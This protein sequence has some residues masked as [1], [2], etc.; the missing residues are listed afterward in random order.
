[1]KRLFLT[2]LCLLIFCGI[3]DARML[4]GVAGAVVSSSS[5]GNIDSFETSPSGGQNIAAYS[6]YEYIAF[7]FTGNG[8]DVHKISLNLRD[9]GSP[10]GLQVAICTDNSGSPSTTCQAMDANI[11]PSSTCT[12]NEYAWKD[13]FYAD[14]YSTTNS[15]TYWIRVYHAL[16]AS[17]YFLIGMDAETGTIIK[18]S[19]DGSSWATAQYNY[20]ANY[21]VSSCTE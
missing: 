7:P 4:Q 18:R 8:S 5:C 20:Q 2:L 19:S 1:M 21:I 13:V 14:G 6:G 12:T 16:D 10:T 9:G 3:A 11:C 17:N 15:T